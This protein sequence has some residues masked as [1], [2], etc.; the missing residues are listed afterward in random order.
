MTPSIRKGDVFILRGPAASD[1]AMPIRTG[2]R[3]RVVFALAA[4][5]FGPRWEL[6]GPG[7]R[8][9]AVYEEDLLNPAAWERV[10]RAFV[11]TACGTEHPVMAPTRTDGDPD[12]LPLL[13]ERW[14]A[15]D[16][17]TRERTRDGLPDRDATRACIAYFGA[18]SNTVP[19]LPPTVTTVKTDAGWAFRCVGCV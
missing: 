2:D 7:H 17:T 14:L 4:S 1:G 3:C 5:T 16:A 11:C 9:G 6:H 10:P 15:A 13:R 18:M 8:M 19:W 12:R